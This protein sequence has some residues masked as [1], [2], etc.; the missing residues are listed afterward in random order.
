MRVYVNLRVGMHLMLVVVIGTKV[1]KFFWCCY[2]GLP[3]WLWDFA[4]YCLLRRACVLQLWSMLI[5]KSLLQSLFQDFTST[6]VSSKGLFLFFSFLLLFS[7]SKTFSVCLL[8]YLSLDD[9]GFPPSVE[10]GRLSQAR[11]GWSSLTLAWVRFQYCP[12][13]MSSPGG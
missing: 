2:S 1:F 5:S 8:N 6:S 7:F 4:L 13:V 10:L 11:V 9:F 12:L 3:S